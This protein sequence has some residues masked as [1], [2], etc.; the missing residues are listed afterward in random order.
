MP[1]VLRKIFPKKSS[2]PSSPTSPA[3]QSTS[4]ISPASPSIPGTSDE[5]SRILTAKQ[6]RSRHTSLPPSNAK[7]PD[8]AAARRSLDD[9]NSVGLSA[10]P[11]Q[12]ASGSASPPVFHKRQGD[13][14]DVISPTRAAPP[15]PQ[16]A[17][18]SEPDSPT[19][20]S[21]APGSDVNRR[22]D[23]PPSPFLGAVDGREVGSRTTASSAY[24]TPIGPRGRHPNRSSSSSIHLPQPSPKQQSPHSGS[25]PGDSSVMSSGSLPPGAAPASPKMH[26]P[27]S[28]PPPVSPKSPLDAVTRQS[29]IADYVTPVSSSLGGAPTANTPSPVRVVTGRIDKPLV[30][31]SPRRQSEEVEMGSHHSPGGL[32]S[33][34]SRFSTTASNLPPVPA[35]LPPP[36]SA[37]TYTDTS[38]DLPYMAP[39]HD[40]DAG[41]STPRAGQSSESRRSTRRNSIDT[42]IPARRSSLTNLQA[43]A[44]PAGTGPMGSV[45]SFETFGNATTSSATPLAGTSREQ[46]SHGV[47]GNGNED[48]LTRQM[49]GL[50]LRAPQYVDSPPAPARVTVALS[51]VPAGDSLSP[52][53]WAGDKGSSETLEKARSE[54]VDRIVTGAQGRKA[55]R[56][57]MGEEG[58][59]VFRATG[60]E[61]NLGREGT[62]DAKTKWLEPVIQVGLHHLSSSTLSD[63]R[64]Q[65]H[66]IPREHTEHTTIIEQDIHRHHI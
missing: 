55:K 21:T 58:R 5:P 26:Y 63:K 45:S 53:G 9:A 47:N 59:E 54:L 51:E 60:L 23:S 41:I 43:N 40:S 37:Y 6:D 2:T 16:T 3:R 17:L 56:G 48:N 27:S 10:S 1:S 39:V 66:I 20:Q 36:S 12:P 31:E 15:P 7:I 13:G 19:P 22:R 25:P 35:G 50:A 14:P 24:I 49:N 64:L 28:N 65:E 8:G 11:T 57:E 46:L 30:A 61:E 18:P 62:V 29:P 33:H 38:T 32:Q 34:T 52:D 4:A 44:V 42:D